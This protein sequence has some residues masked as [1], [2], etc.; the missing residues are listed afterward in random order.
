MSIESKEFPRWVRDP[1]YSPV[2]RFLLNRLTLVTAQGDIVDRQ[3]ADFRY[4]QMKPEDFV[5]ERVLVG[6]DNV[7]RLCLVRRSKNFARVDMEMTEVTLRDCLTDFGQPVVI[8]LTHNDFINGFKRGEVQNK[9]L[10]LAWKNCMALCL[11]DEDAKSVAGINE[12]LGDI[13][14]SEMK[15]VRQDDGYFDPETLISGTFEVADEAIGVEVGQ[16]YVSEYIR[17]ALGMND[18]QHN[19]PASISTQRGSTHRHLMKLMVGELDV[20]GLATLTYTSKS[21]KILT[22]RSENKLETIFTVISGSST[23]D[24]TD[25]V[26][27]RMR[28]ND[29]SYEYDNTVKVLFNIA[30]D[31]KSALELYGYPETIEFPTGAELGIVIKA[32]YNGVDVTPTSVPSQFSS[33]LGNVVLRA[34]GLHKGGMFFTGN[35]TTAITSG[36]IKDLLM[37][38]FSHTADSQVFVATAFVEMTI[39]PAIAGYGKLTQEL[40]NPNGLAG[41]LGQ[42]L[43]TNYKASRL[44][45]LIDNQSLNLPYGEDLG[46]KKLI[47]MDYGEGT[48]LYYTVVKDSGVTGVMV[49]DTINIPAWMI[50]ENATIW[51]DT[52]WI[53]PNIKK[54]SVVEI[55]EINTANIYGL[56]Y[57]A[58]DLPVKIVVDGEERSHLFN[59]TMIISPNNIVRMHLDGYKQKGQAWMVLGRNSTQ[60]TV[61][62]DFVGTVPTVDGLTN[63]RFSKKF[64]LPPFTGGSYHPWPS[65]IGLGGEKGSASSVKVCIYNED[66]RANMT[67]R[68]VPESSILT[69]LAQ[70]NGITARAEKEVTITYVLKEIGSATTKIAF[71][72]QDIAEPLPGEIGLLPVSVSVR[73]PSQID[74]EASTL[75]TWRPFVENELG[76]KITFGGEVIP[77]TDPRLTFDTTFVGQPVGTF[78]GQRK[79]ADKIFY[80]GNKDANY[81]NTV[82]DFTLRIT[83]DIGGGVTYTKT[84]AGAINYLRKTTNKITVVPQST[85][86]SPNLKQPFWVQLLDENND[87]LSGVTFKTLDLKPLNPGTPCFTGFSQV[88]TQDELFDR[89]YNCEVTTNHVG[90]AFTVGGTVTVGGRDFVLT[91]GT[92][93][94]T[95]APILV[96]NVTP[97]TAMANATTDITFSVK[98]DRI[99]GPVDLTMFE[100]FGINYDPAKLTAVTGLAMV[101]PGVMR[102][103]ITSNGTEG[104]SFF[105]FVGKINGPLAGNDLVVSIE[106]PV[107]MV[108]P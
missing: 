102:A 45:V 3:L 75:V 37:G 103:K 100:F 96:S 27:I 52:L 82:I 70:F 48:K 1:L 93:S 20:T 9:L 66:V 59:L 19:F 17:E 54:P 50:D 72:G 86:L 35:V 98:Q 47:R 68:Y 94:I 22:S 40:L 7:K 64:D 60:R 101:S 51:R 4:G 13:Y 108:K 69:E 10:Y 71:T 18:I 90:D 58:G 32:R 88:V 29:G 23:V 74:V 79:T 43:Y 53:Y 91:T 92:L 63:I 24:T 44:G 6:P 25:E 33:L 31:T 84:I 80:Y 77:N 28:Y 46:P 95:P 104:P 12:L 85:A 49:V 42:T 26:S 97:G 99:G 15:L 89:R 41:V 39:G 30:K 21:G 8:L 11:P 36:T 83:F 106:V 65:S 78:A 38:T 76:V 87:F 16:I 2:K 81:A 67:C 62:V 57:V 105:S 107:L 5:M 73:A 56:R 14:F 55:T 61:T 34:A